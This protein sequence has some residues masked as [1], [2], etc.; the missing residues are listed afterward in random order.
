[1]IQ[2]DNVL[3]LKDIDVHE[4]HGRGSQGYQGHPK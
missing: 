4:M 3:L 1:M 2:L